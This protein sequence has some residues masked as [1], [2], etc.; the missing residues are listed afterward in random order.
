MCMDV[1]VYVCVCMCSHMR[2]SL[3]QNM[4]VAAAIFEKKK[5]PKA[6]DAPVVHVCVNVCVYVCV[7]A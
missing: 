3:F 6:V 4:I 7:C 1:C 5:K 2:M